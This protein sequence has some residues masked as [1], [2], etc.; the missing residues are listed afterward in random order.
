MLYTC[1]CCGYKTLEEKPP[2]TF[3][4]CSICFWEDDNVQFDDP[5]YKSGANDISL[6]EAQKNFIKF[7][8]KEKRVISYVRK[9][10][11]EDKKDPKWK[12]LPDVIQE[13]KVR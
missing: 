13:L 12:I 5:D 8:A 2:G 4:I 10:A 7:G 9:P 11:K 1:P 3:E 6:R